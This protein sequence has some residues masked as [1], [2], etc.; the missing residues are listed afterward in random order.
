MDHDL[1]LLLRRIMMQ[2]KSF[3]LATAACAIA[4]GLAGCDVE[5]TQSGNV[6]LPKYEVTKQKEGDVKLPEYNVRG[7]D[8]DVK[9]EKREITVPNVDVN[10]RKE[11]VTVPNVDIKTPQEKD[12]QQSSMG[13]R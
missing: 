1:I 8:V 4:L 10:T 7:P 9:T 2:T 3:T 13:N 6:D 11:T 5:K 12:R